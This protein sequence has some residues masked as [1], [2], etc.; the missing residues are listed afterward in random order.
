MI[1]PPNFLQSNSSNVL[2][3]IPPFT[4][5][6]SGGGGIPQR[7]TFDSSNTPNPTNIITL[8]NTPISINS[9]QVKIF[10]SGGAGQDIIPTRY[11]LNGRAL[12]FLD[13]VTLTGTD[14]LVIYYIS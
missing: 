9:I 11:T 8:S 2:G 12:T 10:Q 14:L 6:S 5:P 4:L 7:D 13:I 3:G 1:K